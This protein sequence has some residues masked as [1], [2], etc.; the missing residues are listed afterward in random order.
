MYFKGGKIQMPMLQRTHRKMT[1]AAKYKYTCIR[2]IDV[3][4]VIEAF[5][6]SFGIE[7]AFFALKFFLKIF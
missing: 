1:T 3:S 6:R 5:E 2:A 4:I 7:Y